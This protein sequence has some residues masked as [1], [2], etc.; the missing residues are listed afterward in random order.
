MTGHLNEKT[1]ELIALAVA[2][3]LRCDAC[4]AVHTAAARE[5]HSGA[6]ISA[7]CSVVTTQ[8]GLEGLT[9]HAGYAAASRRQ[10]IQAK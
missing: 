4:I 3:T 8:V 7:I 2:I 9:G 10:R 1:R 5:R 6:A